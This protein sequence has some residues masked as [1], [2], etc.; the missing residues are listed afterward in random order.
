[1][2]CHHHH[3]KLSMFKNQR[4]HFVP[5]SENKTLSIIHVLPESPPFTTSYITWLGNIFNMSFFF[6][7]NHSHSL[8]LVILCFVFVFFCF[9]Q[10]LLFSSWILLGS[11]ITW[12]SLYSNLKGQDTFDKSKSLW[13]GS[14]SRECEHKSLNAGESLACSRAERV[15]MAKMK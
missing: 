11:F 2:F 15:S 14:L 6:F 7:F 4:L 12:S 9:L 1:M 13:Q 10:T 5:Q 8:W 3:L